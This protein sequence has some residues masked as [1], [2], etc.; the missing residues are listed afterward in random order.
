MADKQPNPLQNIAPFQDQSDSDD[1]EN[2]N[3]YLEDSDMS[4]DSEINELQRESGDESS[5][6]GFTISDLLPLGKRAWMDR[7]ASSPRTRLA[8]GKSP[9]KHV[10]IPGTSSG[11]NHDQDRYRYDSAYDA[12]TESEIEDLET[13]PRHNLLGSKSTQNRT[14]NEHDDDENM[15]HS[16]MGG[17]DGSQPGAGDHLD[18][19]VDVDDGDRDNAWNV[20]RRNIRGD[21]N[22]G[23]RGVNRDAHSSGA[24]SHSDAD[25]D[26]DRDVRRKNIHGDQNAGNRGVNRD[27][28]SSGADS[29]SDADSDGYRD[30]RRRNI[31]GDQNDGNLG[32]NSDAADR[33]GADSH[34]DADSDGDSDAQGV[35]RGNQNAGNQ[36]ANRNGNPNARNIGRGRGRGGNQNVRNRRGGGNAGQAALQWTRI[37][38]NTPTIH[39]FLPMEGLSREAEDKLPNDRPPTPVDYLGLYLTD[40]I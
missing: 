15:P 4:L 3:R 9:V 23:N 39:P 32:S 24:D 10:D 36:G 35:R 30:V 26:G 1:S 28:H 19:N 20:R 6:D 22:A 14:E 25:S 2:S 31:R 12:E 8:L 18:N 17:S 29:H 33:S 34:G 21:Q 11:N 37:H 38:R 13:E 27:A 16:P 7:L 40:E 5:D